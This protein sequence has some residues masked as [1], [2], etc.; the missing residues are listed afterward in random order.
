MSADSTIIDLPVAAK[1]T[2]GGARHDSAA[3]VR[4]GSRDSDRCR[5][6]P[7]GAFRG[8]DPPN[9]LKAAFVDQI[10]RR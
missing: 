10:N 1:L 7:M 6:L 3:G 9:I 2:A 4:P 8:G 5:D